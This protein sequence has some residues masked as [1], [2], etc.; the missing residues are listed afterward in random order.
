MFKYYLKIFYKKNSPQS[1]NISILFPIIGT[2]ISTLSVVII[3]CV[4]SSLENEIKNT[5]ISTEGGATVTIKDSDKRTIH[6]EI[7]E[8]QK[9][10]KSIGISSQKIISRPSIISY[11]N[12]SIFV[13]VIGLEDF[14]FLEKAFDLSIKP[15]KFEEGI[16]I[17]SKLDGKLGHPPSETSLLLTS[18][19]DSGISI[20]GKVFK[21]ID[22]K[23]FFDNPTSVKDISGTYV[24][25]SYNNAKEVF[26]L[27]NPH[28]VIN[29]ELSKKELLNIENNLKYANVKS[30]Q[31]E[32]PLFFAA[33]KLE[34]FLYT[35]FGFI[36]LLIVSFNIF[37][38]VNLIIIRKNNQL[39]SLLYFGGSKKQLESIF[40]SNILLLGFLGSLIGGTLSII[41]L[42]SNILINYSLIPSM[43]KKIDLYFP[44]IIISVI[45][46][47]FILFLSTKISVKNNIRNIGA[48]KSNAIE[49]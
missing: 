36:I 18:P 32:N 5:L 10:L 4:M 20:S 41:I 49:G 38:L 3:F 16:L 1:F 14:N 47:L 15:S 22:E 35:T 11:D 43:I 28:I 6:K 2:A 19:L 45:F 42:E 34:K 26:P 17:G 30:W 21:V 13:N 40:N 46:N 7:L 39:S 48:L 8:I 33:I 9:Y 29:R 31:G 24:Y 25:I 44:I 27:S 37:G 23:F 12:K